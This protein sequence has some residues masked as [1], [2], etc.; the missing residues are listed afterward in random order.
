MGAYL[1][2]IKLEMKRAM[3]TLPRF[4]TGAIV[5]VFLLGTI[6]FSASKTMYGNTVVNRITVGVVLPEADKLA[7]KAVE[8][9]VSMDSVKSLCDFVYMNEKAGREQLKSGVLHALLVVPNGLVRDIITGVNSPITI[10]LPDQKNIQS[11]VFKELADSGARTLSV[12]QASIYAAGDLCIAYQISSEIRHVEDQ[13]NRVYFAYSLPREDYFR[14][15]KVSATED[16]S[17]IQYYAI[18]AAMLCLF[19]SGIPLAVFCRP[20]KLVLQQKLKMIN[21]GREKQILAKILAVTVLMAILSFVAAGTLIVLEVISFR[22]VFIFLV[23]LVSL[24]T[25]SIVVAVYSITGNP[26]V[27]VMCLFWMTIVMLF[28]AGG[29]VPSVFLPESM[30]GLADFVP[31]MALIDLLKVFAG[32]EFSWTP[33]TRAVLWGTGFYLA[34]VLIRR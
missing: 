15:Y 4:F 19:F 5:L 9:L 24:V 2:Y 26:I 34:A 7:E 21:I 22:P 1:I 12:A 13:L 14:D 10:V 29:L 31:V 33:V 25:A 11:M 6:A 16:L 20:D 30:R 18:S 3:K 28:L 23:L 32:V 17:V 27:G 8:M